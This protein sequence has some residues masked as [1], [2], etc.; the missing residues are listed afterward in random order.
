MYNQRTWNIAFEIQLC[1]FIR[2]NKVSI[3]K[4]N[5]S[6]FIKL[7][8][9]NQCPSYINVLWAQEHLP[10]KLLADF[11]HANVNKERL[12]LHSIFSLPKAQTQERRDLQWPSERLRYVCTA[13]FWE[14]RA[15]NNFYRNIYSI[16]HRRRFQMFIVSQCAVNF[17]LHKWV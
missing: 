17:V 6:V 1:W 16:L 7:L 10:A 15:G 14:G 11:S 4:T 8:V 12:D 5:V 13:R 9:P 2:K 3:S